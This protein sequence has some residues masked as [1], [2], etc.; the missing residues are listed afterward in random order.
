MIPLINTN[1]IKG[2]S[3]FILTTFIMTSLFSCETESEAEPPD[4]V[5]ITGAEDVTSASLTL[6]WTQS[7]NADFSKSQPVRLQRARS[8]A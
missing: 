6:I 2:V 4:A 1:F 3:V 8:V 5:T 7:S